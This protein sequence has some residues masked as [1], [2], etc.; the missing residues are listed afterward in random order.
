[1]TMNLTIGPVNY[2][3]DK[4]NVKQQAKLV[5][6]LLP[7]A[8]ALLPYISSR[9][10]VKSMDEGSMIELLGPLGDLVAAMPDKDWDDLISTC[11]S[12]VRRQD[13]VGWQSVWNVQSDMPQYMDMELPEIL[14]LVGGVLKF[15]L[16]PFMAALP[17]IS[18]PA[19]LS[20]NGQSTG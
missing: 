9:G 16:G 13:G 12:V 7:F 15:N 19:P 10:E 1:M 20:P 2:K 6:K 4:L 5:R 18:D 14:Q 11:M 8:K 3:I 17:R